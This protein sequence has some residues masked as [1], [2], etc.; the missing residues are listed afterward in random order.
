MRRGMGASGGRSACAR[1]VLLRFGTSDS[2]WYASP[3]AW[4]FSL[5]PPLSGC[6]F[7]ASL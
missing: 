2:T 7:I 4:N 3:M 5:S 6:S 1:G